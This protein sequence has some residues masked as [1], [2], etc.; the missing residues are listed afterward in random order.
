ML[1]FL[2][3]YRF[4]ISIGVVLLYF[5][6]TLV[7]QI[8][9]KRAENW[10]SGL[11]QTLTHPFLLVSETTTRGVS[12]LWNGYIALIHVQEQ[13]Q[14]LLEEIK[15]LKEEVARGQEIRTAFN[16]QR[17]LLE[18][19]QINQ[20]K[21]VFA[22]VVG[23]VKRGFSKL[24]VLNKGS[25]DG[26]KRNFAVV[27]PE[28]VVGKIQSVTPYGSVVQLI[29]DP[30][31]QFPVLVQRNRAKAMIQGNL[32]GSL[33]IVHFPRRTDLEKGDLVITSG[34]AGI[35][36]KGLAV[37][38]VSSIEKKEFGLFQNANLTPA[39]DLNRLEEVIVILYVRSNIHQPLFSE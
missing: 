22:E 27:T 35:M 11:I 7:G 31:S 18:F 8:E 9:A 14:Q 10:F 32:E 12:G 19:E 5:F 33:N 25:K 1:A 26:I 2:K 21:K 3:R 15:I 6:L 30:N 29:T 4:R 24:L 39:V 16:R 13:N 36:P 17:R 37:G 20:D 28:G 34:L 38:R 23:E